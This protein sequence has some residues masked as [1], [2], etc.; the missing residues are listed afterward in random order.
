MTDHGSSSKKTG[1]AADL[2]GLLRSS[3]I[4]S[5]VVRRILEEDLLAQVSPAHI[6]IAQIHALKLIERDGERLVSDIA[7]FLGVSA[8]AASR[9]LDRLV[10]MGLL[11]RSIP[12]A[13]RRTAPLEITAAGK[14]LLADYHAERIR[15]L[16]PI[17]DRFTKAERAQFRDFADRLAC[18]LI[19][20]SGS[21]GEVCLRC[22]ALPDSAC[23]VRDLVEGCP[24][25]NGT[26][27][28]EGR[29]DRSRKEAVLGAK[30]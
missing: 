26:G 12:V 2:D 9:S 25:E 19:R 15:L 10:R 11:N 4:L 16:R 23:P 18:D 3:H 5:S 7:N 24:F 1:K 28:S 20:E 27:G 6:S 29:S 8:P 14:K 13:D 21:G 30:R 17:L 22:G